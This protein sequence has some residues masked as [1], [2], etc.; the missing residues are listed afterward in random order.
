M[1]IHFVYDFLVLRLECLDHKSS[2]RNPGMI[3]S[4]L[5]SIKTKQKQN[6]DVYHSPENA[7]KL[8]K[9]T[10]TIVEMYT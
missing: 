1:P 7:K 10:T 6:T 5:S 8:T 9:Q 2:I 4:I 3:L